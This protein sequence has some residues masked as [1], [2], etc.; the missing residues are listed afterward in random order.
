K[1]D[2][3][4]VFDSG[5]G[6]IASISANDINATFTGLSASIPATGARFFLTINLSSDIPESRIYYQVMVM[7]QSIVVSNGTGDSSPAGPFSILAITTVNDSATTYVQPDQTYLAYT[8]TYAEN[9]NDPTGALLQWFNIT[10]MSYGSIA[11][12]AN[13]TVLNAADGTLLGYNN[14]FSGFPIC[15]NLSSLNSTAAAVPDN[16]TYKLAVYLTVSSATTDATQIGIN[17]TIT[18]NETTTKLV[19]N[20]PSPET[21]A[22]PGIKII[23]PD[24]VKSAGTT[25]LQIKV[26][27][28]AGNP[29]E[30][31]KVTL[32]G[33][34]TATGFTGS[35]GMVSF[36]IIVRNSGTINVH[37]AYIN[38]AGNTITATKSIVIIPIYFGGGGMWIKPTPSPTPE[39]TPAPTP[40]PTAT[41]TPTPTKTPAPTPT[42][43]KT[44]TR[45]ETPTPA[46][47]K[48]E[49]KK[50]GPGFEAV[51]AVAGLLAVA[52]ILR[53]RR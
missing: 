31:S 49:E 38:A 13:V 41:P 51:F 17:A 44:E 23:A 18:T 30:N 4:G 50:Q 35:D 33:L 11:D 1:D 21:V 20:D 2:G 29:I 3:D 52:Y 15:V 47:T 32:S 10:G 9:R 6:L 39:E 16:S 27:D 8:V 43:V 14:S 24:K 19:V 40:T 5:D 22:I 45:A 42:P 25:V 53:R 7:P 28:N 34:A 26:V 12:I 48:T 36:E 37:A 46:P